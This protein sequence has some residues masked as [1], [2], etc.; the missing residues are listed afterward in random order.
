[1]TSIESTSATAQTIANT[2]TH[3]ALLA[4]EPVSNY[5][6]MGR[7][8]V[9][10]L[11]DD[12]KFPPPIKIGRSS[13]WLKSEIDAWIAAQASARQPVQAGV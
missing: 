8:R 5:V 12:G 10:A 1:M 6:S 13:R 3:P 9:Y 11:I 2:G 7:S 4:F